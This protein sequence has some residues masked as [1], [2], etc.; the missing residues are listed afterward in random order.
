MAQ[1]NR[2]SGQFLFG[3]EIFEVLTIFSWDFFPSLFDSRGL[4]HQRMDFHM[5]FLVNRENASVI[6]II[7]FGLSQQL[8]KSGLLYNF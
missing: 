1:I 3:H 6:K 7:D 5:S 8:I 4:E 2:D